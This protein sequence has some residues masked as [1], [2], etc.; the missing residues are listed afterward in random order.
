MARLGGDEFVVLVEDAAGP[1]EADAVAER[2]LAT[3]S[4]PVSLAGRD[5]PIRAGASVGIV[6]TNGS[7][8][9]GDLLRDADIAMYLA[10]GQGGGH[11]RF[12]PTMPRSRVLPG[13]SELAVADMADE[14]APILRGF[15]PRAR[16]GDVHRH[17]VLIVGEHV[18]ELDAERARGGLHCLGEVAENLVHAAVVTQRGPGP[19]HARRRLDQTGHG[20]CDVAL[21]NASKPLRTSSSFG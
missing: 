3:L 6:T 9:A 13:L 5:R 4:E 18:V 1:G 8:P 12:E 11:R 20:G 17:S 7:A 10:K 19:A 16:R 2:L 21:A 15:R 14:H